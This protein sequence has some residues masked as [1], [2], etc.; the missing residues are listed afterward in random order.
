M[1]TLDTVSFLVIIAAVALLLLTRP[2]APS[3]LLGAVVVA[4]TPAVKCGRWSIPYRSNF[5]APAAT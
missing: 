3:I 1:K 2:N 5:L 4:A